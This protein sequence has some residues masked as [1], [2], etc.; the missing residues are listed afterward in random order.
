MKTRITEL[1]G[2]KYPI[3][4]GAMAGLGDWK[5]AAAV[6]SAGG[7]G[8]ITASV[9]RTPERLREDVKRCRDA[10]GGSFGVNL[11]FG[12][13][14]RIEE[15]LEVCVEERVAVET[16]MYKPDSL[17]PRIKEAGLPWVHKSARVKDAIHAERLGADALIVVGLEGTGFKSPEQM[18]TMATT[19]WATRQMKVPFIAAGG[20]ADARGFLG[21]LAMGAEGVMMGTAFML[22]QECTL[23]D[24]IKEQILRASPE[25]PRFLR[26]VLGSADPRA[27]AEVQAM[28]D[29]VPL[30]QWLR[31]LER[32]N[33]KDSDWQR[34]LEGEEPGYVSAAD[35]TRLVSLALAAIDHIPTV[36]ELI[37]SIVK[38]AGDGVGRLAQACGASNTSSA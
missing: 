38:G 15:M 31:M 30:E 8:T 24:S 23:K 16:A 7:H 35:P 37:D 3:L 36:R 12:I 1:L 14:P 21:A 6:A 13:C 9:S 19:I 22:T 11:S 20:I 26:R 25:D 28:R 29:K 27:I 33:L 17:A 34:P 18:P 5:L 4:Q 10:A 2:C 32:V